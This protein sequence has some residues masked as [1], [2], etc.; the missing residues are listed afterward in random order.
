MELRKT[1]VLI[2]K[3]Q[4]RILAN[5]TPEQE[6]RVK[7]FKGDRAP[8]LWDIGFIAP[9]QV[10]SYHCPKCAK[11]YANP[12]KVQV[13]VSKA[14]SREIDTSVVYHCS[15]C[16]EMVF[17]GHIQSPKDVPEEFIVYDETGDYKKPTRESVDSL[18]VRLAQQ[19]KEGRGNSLEK[20]GSASEL[21]T[22]QRW[23]GKIGYD[24]NPQIESLT[25]TYREGYVARLERELPDLVKEIKNRAYGFNLTEVDSISH[26]EGAGLPEMMNQ[27]SQTILLTTPSNPEVN[28]DIVRIFELYCKMGHSEKERMLKEKEDLEERLASE[29]EFLAQARRQQSEFIQKVQMS[30]EQADEA[31]AT[32]L[33]TWPLND[34]TSF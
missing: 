30:T 29:E 8:E 27:L 24:I 10:A 11:D 20:P 21:E 1:G 34:E 23:A 6:E 33:D 22:A 5:L 16:N 18:L 2:Y 32:P 28:K 17:Y 15:T 13:S 19:A 3:K 12:P 31:R 9:S 26:Y 14:G 25:K 4:V 7:G